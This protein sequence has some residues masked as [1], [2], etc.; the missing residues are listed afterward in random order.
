M[1]PLTGRPASESTADVLT[2]D[3][4]QSF[5]LASASWRTPVN[6]KPVRCDNECIVGWNRARSE[7]AEGIIIIII[8]IFD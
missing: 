3:S 7:D 8:F 4:H 6:V 1:E 2:S 5:T